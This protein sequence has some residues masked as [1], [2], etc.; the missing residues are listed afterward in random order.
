MPNGSL[1]TFSA[2]LCLIVDDY[3]FMMHFGDGLNA[4]FE[5]ESRLS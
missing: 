2:R 1:L 4:H 5:V 3:D